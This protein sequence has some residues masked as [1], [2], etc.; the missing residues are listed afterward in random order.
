MNPY[1][2]INLIKE[3]TNNITDNE[4][5]D[6]VLRSQPFD[7]KF[8]KFKLCISKT[9]CKMVDSQMSSVNV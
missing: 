9:S 8:L 1:S 5:K 7:K 4:S 3:S 6:I 2:I